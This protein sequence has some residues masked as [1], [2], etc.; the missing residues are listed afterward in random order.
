M[1]VCRNTEKHES[2]WGLPE[3][4]WVSEYASVR[5]KAM[6]SAE[7]SHVLHQHHPVRMLSPASERNKQPR[8]QHKINVLNF[9]QS[10][11]IQGSGF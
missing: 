10:V 1:L 6:A 2:K 4:T 11:S 9:P 7:C 3:K 8:R 5:V